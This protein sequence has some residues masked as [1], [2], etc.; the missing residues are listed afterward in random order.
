MKAIFCFTNSQSI[1]ACYYASYL[2][3]RGGT[4]SMSV[5]P[6]YANFLKGTCSI[7]VKPT[8]CPP[9]PILH[10]KKLEEA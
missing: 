9:L 4:M 3:M 7:V 5:L 1:V 10:N 6:S 2:C 8:L